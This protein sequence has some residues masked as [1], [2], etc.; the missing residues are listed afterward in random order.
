MSMVFGLQRALSE[1]KDVANHAGRVYSQLDGGSEPGVHVKPEGR[2]RA[3]LR[4]HGPLITDYTFNRAEVEQALD[5]VEDLSHVHVSVDSPGGYLDAGISIF[6]LLEE[7]KEA[8]VGVTAQV[9]GL[10]ASAGVIPLL[11]AENDRI[12]S[13]GSK[14]MIHRPWSGVVAVA[15]GNSD[16]LLASKE[17]I[18]KQVDEAVKSLNAGQDQL[19]ELLVARTGMAASDVDAALANGNTWYNTDEAL[20]A[21]LVT[22]IAGEK[23]KEDDDPM[24]ALAVNIIAGGVIRNTLEQEAFLRG[25]GARE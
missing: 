2:G 9:S 5:S 16:E 21:G 20:N 17:R 24:A 12:I 25:Q 8:G 18:G 4:V 15:I 19:H 3:L 6:Q 1:M 22:S 23:P 11:A 7:R 10:A 13:P 14:M